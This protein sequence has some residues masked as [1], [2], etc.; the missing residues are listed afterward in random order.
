LSISCKETTKP[1]TAPQPKQEPIKAEAPKEEEPAQPLAMH[2]KPLME[3]PK[4]EPKRKL[5][6]F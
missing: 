4:E 5:R 2:P 3:K 6:L 1:E